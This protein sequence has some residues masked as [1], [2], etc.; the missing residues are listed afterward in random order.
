MAML[1]NKRRMREDDDGWEKAGQQIV[2]S[3]PG[4]ALGLTGTLLS[5]VIAGKMEEAQ[6]PLRGEQERLNIGARGVEDRALK[7]HEDT[8]EAAKA[9]A[10]WNA[11]TAKRATSQGTNEKVIV[12]DWMKQ[13]LLE[14]AAAIRAR[15][16]ESLAANQPDR[17]ATEKASPMVPPPAAP[18][19]VALATDLAAGSKDAMDRFGKSLA[20]ARAAAPSPLAAATR[21]AAEKIEASPGG[22]LTVKVKQVGV[23]PIAAAAAPGALY[24]QKQLNALGD[25]SKSVGD[26]YHADWDT[27]T[28]ANKR[29]IALPATEDAKV[30]RGRLASYRKGEGERWKGPVE[31][32][33]SYGTAAQAYSQAAS[34][35]G[36]AMYQESLGLS[37]RGGGGGAGGMTAEEKAYLEASKA[38]QSMDANDP[39][40][41]ANRIEAQRTMDRLGPMLP[42]SGYVRSVAQREDGTWGPVTTFAPWSAG[43]ASKGNIAQGNRDATAA[44]KGEANRLREE[45]ASAAQRENLA[46]GYE[47]AAEAI[48]RNKVQGLS[49]EGQ[50]RAATL[51]Q[52]A[53]DVRSGKWTP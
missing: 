41:N 53:Q 50:A 4:A 27:E 3:L 12:P 1:L 20:A 14:K 39:T 29:L 28:E 32:D 2:A 15:P 17:T 40:N 33:R 34:P 6:I 26:K 38:L 7:T 19:K 16:G 49:P 31:G 9:A 37:A 47:A 52:M 42:K 44:E 35:L 8:I 46:K 22:D 23:G 5:P 30:A 48:E 25:A 51:R 10:E 24:G 13:Q 45:Q 36:S 18:D 43:A 11:E 21:A